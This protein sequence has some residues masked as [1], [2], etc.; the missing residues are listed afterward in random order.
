[1]LNVPTLMVLAVP[2]VSVPV[3]ELWLEAVSAFHAFTVTVLR[4]GELEISGAAA[5]S[6]HGEGP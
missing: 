5:A 1:M 6:A 2:K 3:P 4:L